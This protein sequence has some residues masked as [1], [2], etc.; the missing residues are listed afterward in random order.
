[1]KGKV[2]RGVPRRNF[3]NGPAVG[4]KA[5]PLTHQV[6]PLTRES[7]KSQDRHLSLMLCPS[8][9]IENSPEP[10]ETFTQPKVRGPTSAA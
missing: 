4:A 9:T 3:T 5:R 8:S 2:V 7:P 1:M 10:V 6:G